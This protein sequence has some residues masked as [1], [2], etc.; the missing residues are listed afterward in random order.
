MEFNFA[1]N[2]TVDNIDSVPGDFRGL[3]VEADGKYKLDTDDPK[4]KSAVSAITGLNTAL[5]A[6]RAEAKAAKGRAVDLSP[7]ADY[8]ESPTTIKE[9]FESKLAEAAKAAKGK[10]NEDKEQAVKAATDALAAKHARELEALGTREQA[11]KGQLH[12]VLVTGAAT[13]ALAEANAV[14]VDLALPHVVSQVRVGEDD[15]KFQVH[16]IDPADPNALRYS[17]TTGKPLT[18]GELVQEM[19]G[20]D[21]YKVLFKSDQRQGGGSPATQRQTAPTP[22][23]DARNS[24]QK[25]GDG[26]AQRFGGR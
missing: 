13:Q 20:Q 9:T 17:G 12:S 10:G 22:K 19:K 3:Y 2:Q 1:Q 7:L 16:V 4:V 26:L 11:L 21:K 14:D 25:I 18:I 15:G 23:G 5:V 8:G 24:T 6:A